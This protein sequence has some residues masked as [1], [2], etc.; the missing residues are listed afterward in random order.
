MEEEIEEKGGEYRLDSSEK[1][2]RNL[3]VGISERGVKVISGDDVS[4]V[5]AIAAGDGGDGGN[6][7]DDKAEEEVLITVLVLLCYSK[8]DFFFKKKNSIL[9]AFK[10]ALVYLLQM[11]QH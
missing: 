10:L 4:F 11:N 5:I 1:E 9:Y 6:A 3:A 2:R 8:Q 7:D